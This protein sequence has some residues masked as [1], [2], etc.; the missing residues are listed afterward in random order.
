MSTVALIGL[1][2]TVWLQYRQMREDRIR[3]VEDRRA[4]E[5]R[6]ADDRLASQKRKW[7][8]V[9]VSHISGFI[10]L[11]GVDVIGDVIFD[12]RFVVEQT[13]YSDMVLINV[14]QNLMTSKSSNDSPMTNLFTAVERFMLP[15]KSTRAVAKFTEKSKCDDLTIDALAECDNRVVHINILI[16]TV[17]KSYYLI[18]HQFKICVNT[19]PE[20]NL[21]LQAWIDAISTIK[22]KLPKNIAGDSLN[23]QLR[24]EL[25]ARGVDIE[26]QIRLDFTPLPNQY[27][28]IEISEADYMNAIE[29]KNALM[30]ENW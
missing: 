12:F 1:W 10:K 17:Q 25:R 4:E 29:K 21:V 5:Q 14:V 24:D 16:C 20:S 22:G 13:N 9:V 23:Q 7:P 27:K 19:N 8:A 15:Q 3:Y 2:L 6:R 11:A 28:F 26:S 18:S 30:G